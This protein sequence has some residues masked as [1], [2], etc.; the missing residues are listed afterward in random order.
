MLVDLER[1]KE[2]ERE[3]MELHREDSHMKREIEEKAA[4]EKDLRDQ[5]AQLDADKYEMISERDQINGARRDVALAEERLLQK[6]K[7]Y[8]DERAKPDTS[9][10]K[11]AAIER[12]RETGVMQRTQNAFEIE[13]APTPLTCAYIA[14]H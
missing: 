11:I 6:T 12:K 9:A 14:I 2:L 7:A 13:V 3:I 4:E 8:E 5:N 10:E 1:K